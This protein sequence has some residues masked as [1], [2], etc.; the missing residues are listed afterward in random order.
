M[1]H[2]FTSVYLMMGLFSGL[3]GCESTLSPTSTDSQIDLT[4]SSDWDAI[5]FDVS[6]GEVPEGIAF[7]RN[8]HLLVGL[9][10][11]GEI[12]RIDSDGLQTSVASLPPPTGGAP[13]LLGLATTAS[14]D[15]YAALVTFDPATRGVYRIDSRTGATE[16]LAGSGAICWPNAFAFDQRGNLYVT[17]STRVPCGADPAED[18]GAIWR[19][20]PGGGAEP[21]VRDAALAGTGALG[22]GVPIG[23]NG[24]AFRPGGGGPGT[25][26][27]ANT[28]AG[29][30]L[31]VRIRP[32]GSP[33]AVEML[34]QDPRIFPLDGI[35]MDVHG[36][37]YAMV[38]GQNT[39]VKVSGD[40][41]EFEVVAAGPPLNLP[42]NA[43]FGTRGEDR[44][45]LFVTNFFLPPSSLPAGF[46]PPKPGI[47]VIDAID[48][49]APLP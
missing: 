2:L 30:L 43:A 14:G 35:V 20:P 1:R 37:I 34:A 11:R 32:D 6:S 41:T 5:D 24:I 10:P 3:L 12:R 26:I 40:G 49:G 23:A 17:E 27:V 16:R 13:G 45:R 46:P 15:I 36:S 39:I 47:V 4:M 18:M 25:L 29:A 44:R 21:W 31:S 48:P 8:G 38:I 33:G 42:V 9:A 7:D 19:I 22:L 28:E